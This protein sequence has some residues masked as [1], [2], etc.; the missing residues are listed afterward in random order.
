LTGDNQ[1]DLAIGDHSLVSQQSSLLAP[2]GLPTLAFF[3][4]T[5]RNN[6]TQNKY[7]STTFYFL[8]VEYYKMPMLHLGGGGLVGKNLG[9]SNRI[10]ETLE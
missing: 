8:L 7:S 10:V 5:T 1:H 4:T 3:Y 9:V 2:F 6:S